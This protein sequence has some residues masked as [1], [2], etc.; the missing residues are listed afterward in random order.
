MTDIWSHNIYFLYKRKYKMLVLTNSIPNGRAKLGGG[1]IDAMQC[2]HQ[3]LQFQTLK[4]EQANIPRRNF[5]IWSLERF[6]W[7]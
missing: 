5:Q 6:E 3:S 1:N 7:A 4:N 2:K